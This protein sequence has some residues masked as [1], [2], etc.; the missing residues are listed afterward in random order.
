MPKRTL[1]DFDHNQSDPNDSDFEDAPS[2]SR[3]NRRR[4]QKKSSS[5][6]RH[7]QPT[8]RPRNRYA[9]DSDIVS[10]NDEISED[11]FTASSHSEEEEPI[12]NP[13]TGRAIRR[14]VA[15]KD[16]KYLE[17]DEDAEPDFIENTASERDELAISP[18][19]TRKTRAASAQTPAPD[20]SS[21]LKLKFNKWKALAIEESESTRSTPVPPPQ[22]RSRS[23]RSRTAGKPPISMVGTRKSSRLSREP[24]TMVALSSSGRRAIPASTAGTS[25]EEEEDNGGRRNRG[26]KGPSTGSKKPAE[27]QPRKMPSTVMEASQE[28]TQDSG[29]GEEPVIPHEVVESVEFPGVEVDDAVE[30]EV[31]QTQEVVEEVE[32]EPTQRGSTGESEGP[33]APGRRGGRNLR[34]S[35]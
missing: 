2:S 16:V 23:T 30:D 10:D 22:T 31:A 7:S 19:K 13:A 27:K 35:N 18:K 6:P 11:G 24:D 21:V 29:H 34:V 26:G 20:K 17:S 14:V 28:G 15:K 1:Q 5:R 4:S 33:I 12:K 9:H 8:K 25:G 32:R 3:P